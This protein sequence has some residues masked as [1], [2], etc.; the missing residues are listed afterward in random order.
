MIV[1]NPKVKQALN[2]G[3]PVVAMESTVISHGLPYPYNLGVAQAMRDIIR[4]QGATP[5][6]IAVLGGK[7]HVGLDADALD[8]LAQANTDKQIKVRKIGRHGLSLAA[9]LGLD[10]ATTVSATMFVAHK[11]G[12]KVFATGGIGGVHRSADAAWDISTDLTTLGDTP[13]AVV[14]AGAKAILDLPATRQVLETNGVPV[15]G[16]QSSN[17]A[18]FYSRD[19]GLPVDCQAESPEQVAAILRAHHELGLKSGLLVSVPV[20]QE[21]EIPA[22]DL[23]P[24]INQAHNEAQEQGIVGAALTPFILKRLGELTQG[25]S[26]R[27]NISLLRNNALVAA[28]I[29]VAL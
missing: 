28:K 24:L 26:T 5:A 20:P 9:G 19:S 17:M 11:V 2:Q 7:I 12:I 4:E 8:Y 10:G 18:A 23:E 21:D 29:A 25:R 3:Q 1:L 27:T 22:L 6:T 15:I 14:C 13:V 16:Y